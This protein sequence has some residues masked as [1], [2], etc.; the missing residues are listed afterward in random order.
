MWGGS[1]V[2]LQK[3]YP[4]KIFPFFCSYSWADQLVPL[5]ES[6]QA[7]LSERVAA[8]NSAEPIH[9]DKLEP[10]AHLDTGP[11]GYDLYGVVGFSLHLVPEHLLDK[12]RVAKRLQL[13]QDRVDSGTLRSQQTL[14]ACRR[15]FQR[16][17]AG[18]KQLGGASAAT[19]VLDDVM[20][21]LEPG[22]VDVRPLVKSQYPLLVGAYERALRLISTCSD[23]SKD[24]AVQV[25]NEMGDIMMLSGNMR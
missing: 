19:V 23:D 8:C 16:Y 9:H 22:S 15:L 10:A 1:K 21:E 6:A 4:H 14:M 18:V 25:L 3:F 24:L 13:Q 5:L 20:P 12:E 2:Y 17:A 11:K 7:K